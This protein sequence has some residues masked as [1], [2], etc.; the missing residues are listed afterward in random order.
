[1]PLDPNPLERLKID[2]STHPTQRSGSRSRWIWPL[3]VLAL[4]L[5]AGFGMAYFRVHGKGPSVRTTLVREEAASGGANR[6]VL[7]ASGYVT[8]RRE[9]TVSAKMTGKVVEVLVEEGKRVEANQILARLDTSN[10][11]TNKKLAEAQLASA[12]SALNE[13]EAVLKEARSAFERVQALIAE[14]IS[15]PADRDKAEASF[16]TAQ[17]RFERQQLEISVAE[18]GLEV[19]EQQLE[20]TII[21]APFAGIVTAKNA[22][23]GETISPMS[24]GGFTRTGICTLVDMESLEIEVDVNESFI[25]R[26]TP[27][28]E[29]Q[30]VLDAYSDWK[31]PSKVIAIIPTADRQ[32]ATVRVR[33]GFHQLDPRILPQMGVK[34]AFQS[35]ESPTG[36]NSTNTNPKRLV[37]RR[38]IQESNGRS[39]VWLVKPSGL[40]RRAIQVAASG[41]EDAQVTAGLSTGDRVVLDPDP[42]LA[43]GMIVQEL[44]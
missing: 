43:E 28:Q 29:V 42:N 26:V 24:A 20:D 4:A 8:A 5:A 10:L 6:T 31:I 44:K 2:R 38:A 30:A 19:W 21:R 32:K 15:S 33:V 1:M 37:L 25:G 35:F 7:N 22:Q 41:G 36:L 40:E 16:K 27:G 34:V 9:A 17:A 12:R 3:G 13:T 11:M 23:P 14:K 18:R 39:Y